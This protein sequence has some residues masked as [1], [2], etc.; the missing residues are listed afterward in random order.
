MAGEQGR[1]SV[2]SG[3]QVKKGDGEIGALEGKELRLPP[4]VRVNGLLTRERQLY[5]VMP[6]IG[7]MCSSGI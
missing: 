6:V 2:Q 5:P 7:A 1:A 3:D 4:Y